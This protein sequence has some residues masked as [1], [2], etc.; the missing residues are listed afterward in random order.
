MK[1]ISI[2]LPAHNEENGIKQTISSLPIKSLL[3][4]RYKVEIV[5][6]DNNST[7]NTVTVAKS[8]GAKVLSEKKQ[9]YGYAYKL[10]FKKAKGD[11]II[12]MDSDG[13]YPGAS[14]PKIVKLLE[15]HDIVIA[16]RLCLGQHMTHIIR[17]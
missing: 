4:K 1:T 13:T 9:G 7:D 15:T 5:V 17:R 11:F 8:L 2:V 3:K 12:C 14:I 6:V 10:G 16:N